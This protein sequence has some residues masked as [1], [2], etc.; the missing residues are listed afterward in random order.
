MQTPNVHT[1]KRVRP[2][3]YAYVLPGNQTTEGYVK[4]GYTEQDVRERVKQQ[5]HTAGLKPKILWAHEAR[6]NGGSYF[7]D[8]DFHQYLQQFEVK[9][10]AGNEWF[11]FDGHPEEAEQYFKNFVFG[12]T[13]SALAS[14][15]ARPYR[16]RAEQEEAVSQAYQYFKAHEGR[17]SLER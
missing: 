1:T 16:L 17:I 14:L 2:Q 8:H 15:E 6:F 4:I 13:P 3:I 5:T 12:E 10:Q 11:Y 9:R 7:K